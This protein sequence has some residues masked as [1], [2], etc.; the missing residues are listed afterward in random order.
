MT[1]QLNQNTLMIK[2]F[3]RLKETHSFHLVANSRL[4]ICAALALFFFAYSIVFYFHYPHIWGMKKMFH[5]SWFALLITLFS[6]CFVIVQ[7]SAKGF[8]TKL[9]RR[10]L[11][12]G[13]ALF[14]VSEIFFFLHFFEPSFTVVSYL[15]Q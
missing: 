11:R 8:H 10:G 9:V 4:P 2:P 14:I 13:V 6:W 15:L 1:Q 3:F 12:Y 5:E 7:E